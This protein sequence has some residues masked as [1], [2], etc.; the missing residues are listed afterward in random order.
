MDNLLKYQ[1]DF[2]QQLQNQGKSF[3][4]I[5]NYRTDL[6]C[7]NNF[8][9]EKKKNLT[10]NE[11]GTTQAKEYGQY[12]ASK[13]D[14]D[15]SRR[16]RVQA[17]RIFFDFLVEHGHFDDNPIKKV[18]VSPKVLEKPN[19]TSF[20]V[21]KQLL[22]RVELQIEQGNSMS[23]LLGMRNKLLVYLIYGGGLKVSDIAKL[24]TGNILKTSNKDEYRVLIS[25]PKRDP[26]TIP[27]PSSFGEVYRTYQQMLERQKNL[28]GI[29]FDNILFNA[30][31]F[32]IL[33]G[34]LSARGCEVIFKE[35]SK[36]L[37]YKITPRSLRQACIFKW[38]GQNQP[39]SSVKEWMGVQP[40]YSLK[41]FTELLKQEPGNFAFM[42]LEEK[43]N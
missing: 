37:D 17:L 5:K 27:L 36:T 26:Y 11:F 9:L 40:S 38:L 12:I 34:G 32:K 33:S 10:V 1:E 2:L 14:S 42:E 39:Q 29:D 20:H 23:P 28:D 15:N 4:T 19:P 7:F 22:Y 30:N 31:P 25:H 24:K 21:I 13:Y 16:R 35:F 3:N 6:K 18:A 43:L 41:P 8:L